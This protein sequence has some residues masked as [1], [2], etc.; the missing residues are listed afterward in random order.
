MAWPIAAAVADGVVFSR[1]SGLKV[2]P[3][4][5]RAGYGTFTPSAARDLM[6]RP[7][8][9]KSDLRN[10]LFAPETLELWV[11]HAAAPRT[12]NYQA[13][14]QPYQHYNFKNMLKRYPIPQKPK[15]NNQ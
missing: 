14:Y 15:R 8:A 6:K 4:W 2:L 12:P 1:P 7:V 13:C 5:I 3:K 9:M 11:A 10:V